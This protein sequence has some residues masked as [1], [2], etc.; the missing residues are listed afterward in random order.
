[1]ANLKMRHFR[2]LKNLERHKSLTKVAHIMGISQPAATKMLSEIEDL[3]EAPLFVRSG[4]GLKPTRMGE[5]AMLRTAHIVEEFQ[6][7]AAEMEAVRCGRDA[8]LIIGAAPYVSG[9]LMSQAVG[10]LYKK[11]NVLSEIKQASSDELVQALSDHQ[12][13]C[14]LAR[15]SAVAGYDD[16]H[17]EILHPQRPVLVGNIVLAKRLQGRK[18]AWHHLAEMDWILPSFGTPV[19]RRVAELFAHMQVQAPS[20]IIETYSIEVMYGI[21]SKNESVISVVPEGIADDMVRR[22]GVGVLP[23][24]MDWELSPLSLI[25]RA[26]N[27]PLQAID[28]FSDIIRSLCRAA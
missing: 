22:G 17:H 16:L 10:E 2:L 6:H 20:P 5:V 25:R 7:F 27:T 14:V 26:R 23:W 19:G 13:D 28:Q 8:R 4:R 9:A 11:H 21:I 15:T 1:M 3:F 12:V 24:K 18:L